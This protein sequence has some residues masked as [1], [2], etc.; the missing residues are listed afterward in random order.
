[1]N[2]MDLVVLFINVDNGIFTFKSHFVV[3][4]ALQDIGLLTYDDTGNLDKFSF[5]KQTDVQKAYELGQS[6]SQELGW[7]VLYLSEPQWYDLTGVD[8]LIIVHPS[9]LFE[10]MY[11]DKF[12][13]K[14]VAWIK[15]NHHTWIQ[16]NILG[17]CHM[18]LTGSEMQKKKFL[19]SYSNNSDDNNNNN[20]MRGIF[21]LKC[22]FKCDSRSLTESKA[23]SERRN[24]LS[25]F[26]L[27]KK[28][29][30]GNKNYLS[31]T[32]TSFRIPVFV[33][34]GAVKKSELHNNFSDNILKERFLEDSNDNDDSYSNDN[35]NNNNDDL[36]RKISY[37][38]VGDAPPP[39][40]TAKI[41]QD[42]DPSRIANQFKGEI[43][44]KNWDYVPLQHETS[45]LNLVQGSIPHPQQIWRLYQS[46]S[47][48]VNE[49]DAEEMYYGIISNDVYHALASGALVI[50]NN[51]MGMKE[52][53]KEFLPSYE[54]SLDLSHVLNSLL[55]N[56]EWLQEKRNFLQELVLEK[57]TYKVRA[58]EFFEYLNLSQYGNKQKGAQ[59]GNSLHD[60]NDKTENRNIN[61]MADNV[62][63]V[64]KTRHSL[65]LVY[66][67]NAM[68]DPQD[69]LAG[70]SRHRTL[71][72][73]PLHDVKICVVAKT[74]LDL[75]HEQNQLEI[76]L[77]S[78]LNQQPSSSSDDRDLKEIA[79]AVSS[80][81]MIY[82]T[83]MNPSLELDTFQ[84][85]LQNIVNKV[86]DSQ[87]T[88][89]DSGKIP[90]Q[91]GNCLASSPADN[92]DRREEQIYFDEVDCILNHLMFHSE[93]THFMITDENIQYRDTWFKEILPMLK[94][95]K[96][97]VAW[98]FSGRTK[99][100]DDPSNNN[101]KTVQFSPGFIKT[102]S[103]VVAKKVI[104]NSGAR[105]LRNGPFDFQEQD[106]GFKFL[107]KNRKKITGRDIELIH[108]VLSVEL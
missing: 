45:F 63:E 42:F 107:R 79:L 88:I 17:A 106:L 18:I 36:D 99:I 51:V 56:R 68:S 11:N 20:A 97:M 12:S 10:K 49:A 3:A 47:I 75:Q 94:N 72:F 14:K 74:N 7:S 21:K 58:Q 73:S 35:D 26:N 81:L 44:G 89:S 55:N 71:G 32:T 86:R 41:I 2:R 82:V 87:A 92:D 29:N 43:Y 69:R 28:N 52:V 77:S 27:G 78:L 6:L 34:R 19:S 33:L 96:Q 9:Y 83:N 15:R 84:I 93:C 38:Y 70:G 54:S 16:T 76:L 48:V 105:F 80:S 108:R 31:T 57:H 50:S 59:E 40:G 62:Q 66:Q 46:T 37:I 23:D 98:D 22:F 67:K 95:G 65:S 4:F 85:D 39:G 30:D 61:S 64:Q 24:S 5:Q 103:V 25:L 100:T 53:F 60:V 1:M 102:S 104:M 91:V 8:L 13:L 90:I 101:R